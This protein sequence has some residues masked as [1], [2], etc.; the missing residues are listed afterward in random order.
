MKTFFE[1]LKKR[2]VY[3]VAIVYGLVA[4]GAVQLA[5]TVLPAFNAP[6]WMQQVFLVAL[7][8]GFPVALIWPGPLISR[9]QGSNGRHPGTACTTFALSRCGCSAGPDSLSRAWP[10]RV[11][12]SGIRGVIHAW[13]E[14]VR[15]TIKPSKRA[16][17]FFLSKI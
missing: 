12:G 2:R 8:L 9:R 11:I 5:G 6:V 15:P 1:E 16:L 17:P 13:P 14:A 7:A 10:W 3:R 4:S